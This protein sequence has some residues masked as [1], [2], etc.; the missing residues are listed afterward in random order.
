MGGPEITRPAHDAQTAT[1]PQVLEATGK[2]TGVLEAPEVSLADKASAWSS[3]LG[4]SPA[5]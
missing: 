2:T 1:P 5:T 3:T 4:I